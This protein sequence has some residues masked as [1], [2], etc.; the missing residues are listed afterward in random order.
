MKARIEHDLEQRLVVE[1]SGKQHAS[2]QRVDD[3]GLH[4]EKSVVVKQ[5]SQSAENHD[6]HGADHRDHRQST[7][8]HKRDEQ[9]DADRDHEG[10]GG[11]VDVKT[12]QHRDE[13]QQGSDIEGQLE[14]RIELGLF[15]H[16]EFSIYSRVIAG[17]D[18]AIHQLTNDLF[19]KITPV[20]IDRA[21]QVNFPFRETNA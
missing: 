10:G 16:A 1:K 6:D 11:R 8:H 14:P 20:R 15:S 3:C 12:H 7:R 18:P 9:R 2:E 17:L 19:V 5:Q 21:N 4:L 13:Q